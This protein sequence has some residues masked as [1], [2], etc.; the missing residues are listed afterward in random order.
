MTNTPL[1]EA[2]RQAAI[3]AWQYIQRNWQSPTGFVNSVEQYPWTTWWDQGSAILG[4][5]A[6]YQLGI[7][8]S[9]EFDQKITRFLKTLE[10]LPLPPTGLPNK[11]Y[12]TNS[13]QM[14][15]G[16]N[17]PDTKGGSGWSVL[18]MA[19]FLL[20]LHVLRTHYPRFSQPI[21]A[22]V[23]QWRLSQLEHQGWLQGSIPSQEGTLQLVQEGR[24]GYEQYA[25]HCLLA[26]GID[27]FN[28]RHSPKT[29]IVEVEDVLLHI[30]RRNLANSNGIN[31]LTS[32][33]YILW[34]LELGWNWFTRIQAQKIVT[35][36]QRRYQRTNILTAVNE[37]A[38]DRSPY[39]IYYSVYSDG[40][41]WNAIS[42][43]G[44]AY[45]QFRQLS[46]KAAFG[47]AALFP[48]HHYA[49]TL[50]R[51]VQFLADKNKGYLAGRYE[52]QRLG[53]NTLLNIN[54][55]AVILESL[56]YQARSRRSLVKP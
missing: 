29:K 41:A 19:R 38:I 27:A 39:F 40:K 46:T 31:A 28:A 54:T 20:S 56:L 24:F 51:A 47:W 9:A 1:S 15:T 30:D 8:S 50:R 26:W 43:E 16:S 48:E 25:A 36:Q 37:D 6:A 5:H 3:W 49:G 44:N 42:N 32:D 10:T 2:D 11:F 55:N 18:D 17:R 45:P 53:V 35:A 14:R 52:N 22:I 33:P 7:I 21:N 13:A 4:I 12:S 34:G 23:G